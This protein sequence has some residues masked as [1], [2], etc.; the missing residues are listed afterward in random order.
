M[1]TKFRCNDRIYNGLTL[2]NVYDQ[3]GNP[4]STLVDFYNLIE[5]IFT[6]LIETLVRIAIDNIKTSIPIPYVI[7]GGKAINNIIN[8][9]YLPKS[10]DFDIHITDN[11]NTGYVAQITDTDIFGKAIADELNKFLS[12]TNN[13][14]F[15]IYRNYI[16]N[17]LKK[18]NLIDNNQINYYMNNDIFYYGERVKSYGLAINGL[19]IYFKFRNDIFGNQFYSN[20]INIVNP[21]ENE[22]IYP[23][24]DIDLEKIINFGMIINDDKYKVNSYDGLRYA[25][26]SVLLS[27]L[28]SY[29]TERPGAKVN[30]NMRKLNS[31]VNITNYNCGFVQKNN[32]S[33][34][35]FDTSSLKYISGQD[36]IQNSTGV[37][38]NL[39]STDL[40]KT[41]NYKKN[42]VDLIINNYLYNHNN[43][44][45]NCVNNLVL[46]HDNLHN[47][48]IIWN[49]NTLGFNENNI[50]N[51]LENLLKNADTDLYIK[52]YTGSLYSYVNDYCQYI[53][54]GLDTAQIQQKLTNHY[55]HNY[56]LSNIVN[57]MSSIFYTVNS[58]YAPYL[59][60]IKDDFYLFRA[61]NFICFNSPN[62]DIFNPSSIQTGDIIYIPFY[63]STSFSTN[64]SFSS[65][66]RPNTF[67]FRIKINKNSKKWLFVN[68]YSHF[69]NE[70]EILLDK[71][72]Y[73]FVTNVDYLPIKLSGGT[74]R[75]VMFIDVTLFDSF[76][77][78]INANLIN[79][80]NHNLINFN[81]NN[82]PNNIYNNHNYLA[83]SLRFPRG[84]IKISL[85]DVPDFNL[86]TRNYTKFTNQNL[87]L[88]DITSLIRELEICHIKTEFEIYTQI[89]NLI[90]ENE[91]INS[92]PEIFLFSL[93]NKLISRENNEKFDMSGSGNK[94]FKLYKKN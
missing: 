84:K 34:S 1:S 48:N 2:N 75:D 79:Q 36:I 33:S 74:I 46:T 50:I 17:I 35:E 85:N 19:F 76:Q 70:K 83:S 42:S 59:Q 28:I 93:N 7:L 20:A 53:H 43:K 67:F 82:I 63:Q 81:P 57:E 62:G 77:D 41:G 11:Q 47:L 32:S 54:F 4:I 10:F 68:K 27:N 31:F 44:L 13:N 24:S 25:N 29:A 16:I 21:T 37:L 8:K 40:L 45:I 23:F 51:F 69:P 78:V 87:L 30:N 18:Y 64:Y 58:S 71:N 49:T 56:N 6:E 91:I 3:N 66:V 65:F 94:K 92:Y 12:V 26:Y 15:T 22:L 14:I 86:R 55:G 5:H 9:K 89:L 39:N 61:Q 72:I 73:M 80:S 90:K 88:Y 38:L 60:Y 52:E